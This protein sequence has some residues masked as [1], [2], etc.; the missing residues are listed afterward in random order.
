M[1]T[2]ND[3]DTKRLLADC[4]KRAVEALR[5][6]AEATPEQVKAFYKQTSD[7]DRWLLRSM[8]VREAAVTVGVSVVMLR[9]ALPFRQRP[10]L[11]SMVAASAGL[12][13]S[14]FDIAN[15]MPRVVQDMLSSAESSSVADAI[16][17]PAVM[18]FEPCAQ[19]ERCRAFLSR[20]QPVLAS[21]VELCRSRKHLL[22]EA[23]SA[24]GGTADGRAHWS[25][26][27]DISG[28]DSAAAAALSD[29]LATAP[30]ADLFAAPRSSAH[31][32]ADEPL[33]L[34]AAD[35]PAAIGPMPPGSSWE[36]VRARH[37]ERQQQTQSAVA[38][39][40]PHLLPAGAEAELDPPRA[41]R[42][43]NAYG[44]DIIE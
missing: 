44:D 14:F 6:F 23:L 32:G 30:T 43:K 39:A 33:P 9:L 35:A 10:W 16:V 22:R 2:A 11:S 29:E 40:A 4:A 19:D 21:C 1:A 27:L 42:R 13:A 34:S 31:D 7:S 37:L 26:S 41:P 18:E 17:C 20:E 12:T 8:Y 25:G 24:L 28:A 38:T 5:P 15:T 3:P 36:A